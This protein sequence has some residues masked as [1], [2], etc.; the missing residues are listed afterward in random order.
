MSGEMPAG[1]GVAADRTLMLDLGNWV[2][3]EAFR[4]RERAECCCGDDLFF[5]RAYE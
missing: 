3:A 1:G 4:R 2:T 5:V